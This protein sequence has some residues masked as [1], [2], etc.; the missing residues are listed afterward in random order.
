MPGI[1]ER[2]TEVRERRPAVDR[3]LRAV[4]HFN[5]TQASQQ[6][7]AVT[8]FGFL[9]FFPILALAFYVVGKV[10][11]LYPDA[12]ADLEKA[13]SGVLPG[14][15]S[16]DALSFDTFA[17][18]ANTIGLIGLVGVLYSGLGWLSALRA[19]LTSVFVVPAREK[20]NFI[21]GKLRDLVS[22]A[23]IG[24]ILVV[25]VAVAGFISGFSGDVLDWVGLDSELGWA[26]K[27]MTAA[28]GVAANVLLFFAIF[29]IL[30]QPEL[31]NRE[32][33]AGALLGAIGFEV[34]KQLSFLLLG[35]TEHQPAFQV[36]GISLILLVWINYFSRLVLLSA[37]WSYTATSAVERRGEHEPGL[38]QGPVSP[39]PAQ[40]AV[41][42]RADD[43]LQPGAAF[44]LGAAAMVGLMALL[45]RKRP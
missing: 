1:K 15:F 37:A 19:A 14:L 34:L 8:Y 25:S 23:S 21:V 31:T 41:M 44:G 24:A 2:L 6:A 10:S 28:L 30:A 33:L 40:A 12:D 35:S 32:L 4:E 9:S 7:G 22:L 13:I 43:K 39:S 42:V 18:H 36:F 16:G 38:V 20:P 45:R 17:Q 3:V 11:V 27:L 29:K 5:D 26:V